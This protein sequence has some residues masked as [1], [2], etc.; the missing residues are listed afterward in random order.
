MTFDTYVK[1]GFC[2]IILS[3]AQRD[4]KKPEQKKREQKDKRH[5]ENKYMQNKNI[6]KGGELYVLRFFLESAGRH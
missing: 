2:D 5:I 1:S 4:I 3:E 6:I